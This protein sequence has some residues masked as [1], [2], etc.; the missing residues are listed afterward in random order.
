MWKNNGGRNRKEVAVWW[1]NKKGYVE[2]RVWVDGKRRR[3]KFHRWI[4]EQFIGRE[5]EPFEDVHHLND[6]KLDN[7]LENLEIIEH[8]KH[9]T[10]HNLRGK[11]PGGRFKAPRDGSG[12]F[13]A[14]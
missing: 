5:L 7:R 6:N 12:R 13:A 4:M 14:D 1:T 10:L 8:G 11:K 9:T 3:Y 2:G